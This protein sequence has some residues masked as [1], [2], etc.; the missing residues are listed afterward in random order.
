MNS[1]FLLQGRTNASMAWVFSLFVLAA[2]IVIGGSS[3]EASNGPQNSG[4]QNNSIITNKQSVWPRVHRA[5]M[6]VRVAKKLPRCRRRGYFLYR[7]RCQPRQRICDTWHDAAYSKARR[8]C[9]R[10]NARAFI[11]Q[12]I[13]SCRITDCRCMLRGGGSRS[14]EAVKAY[15][16][17]KKPKPRVTPPPVNNLRSGSVVNRSD[18]KV[19]KPAYRRKNGTFVS[20]QVECPVITDPVRAANGNNWTKLYRALGIFQRFGKCFMR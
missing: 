8:L 16:K 10:I 7:G 1:L 14:C 2:A 19:I 12:S 4:F 17:R 6:Y 5:A 11:G 3:A 9:A 13:K 18:L 15:L 20:A